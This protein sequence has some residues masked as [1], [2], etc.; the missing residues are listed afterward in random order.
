MRVTRKLKY[1]RWCGALLGRTVTCLL[2]PDGLPK[3]LG[4]LKAAEAPISPVVADMHEACR[5]VLGSRKWYVLLTPRR[6]WRLEDQ[7]K[8]TTKDFV[9]AFALSSSFSTFQQ[10]NY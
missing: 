10:T 2:L 3:G 6:V 4:I 7:L 1:R 5:R 8:G 9:L